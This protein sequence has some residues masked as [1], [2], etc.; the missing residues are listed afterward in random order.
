MKRNNLWLIPCAF[1]LICCVLDLFGCFSCRELE[2]TVKPALMPLLSVTAFVWLLGN[3]KEYTDWTAAALLLFG[4]MFG[5]AGDTLLLGN[6]FVFFAGG[7]GLFLIGHLFYICLF[8]RKSLKAVK[9]WQ[10]VAGI[11]G[12]VLATVVLA[13]AIG[14]NGVM[15]VPM[16]VYAFVLMMLIFSTLMGVVRFGGL[17]WWM[18][19]AGACLFAFSDALI[20]VR[21]FGTEGVL[22]HAFVIMLSYLAAQGLIAAGGLR[23]VTQKP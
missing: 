12:S 18:L 9:G 11:V 4:Q 19:L 2:R 1:F 21:N 6:G 10:W 3:H 20:A 16:G 13:L 22:T 7:I 17:S 15:L 5:F 23:L 8:G 14:A